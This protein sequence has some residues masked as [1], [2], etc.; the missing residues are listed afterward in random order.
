MS[1]V[2]KVRIEFDAYWDGES[3]CAR[4]PE[5]GIYTFADSLDELLKNVKEAAKLYVEGEED[6]K[7]PLEVVLKVQAHVPEVAASSS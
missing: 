7:G 6:L 4:A 1:S 5:R 2:P 3:W